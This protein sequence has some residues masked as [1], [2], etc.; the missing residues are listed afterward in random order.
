[1]NNET[2]A[3]KGMQQDDQSITKDWEMVNQDLI[4]GVRLQ[5]IKNVP[6]NY[7]YLTEVYRADWKL[8]KSGVDQVFMSVLEPGG[9]S[10][11]H[12]H[13]Q[14]TDRLFV[15]Q[16]I[17]K[18]VLFDSRKDSPTYGKLNTFR[19]GTIKPGLLIVPPMV[20]H[21]IQNTSSTPSM[22]INVV[23]NGYDYE[24]PDHYRL[25]IDTTEIPYRF[26]SP[27]R[28]DALSGANL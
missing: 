20:W 16:G 10:A 9:I 5:E 6:T 15:A 17:F 7:G 24:Q 27:S 19:L 11:W 25:P 2:W 13:S 12:A 18:I 14:T 28:Q 26:E 22:L 21:G 23:D 1:M 4:D 3:L 8:D